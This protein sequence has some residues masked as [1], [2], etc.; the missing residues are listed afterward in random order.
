M[1]KCVPKQED[2]TSIPPEV[3]HAPMKKAI[4]KKRKVGKKI[5]EF[6]PAELLDAAI[7]QS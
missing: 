6:K 2:E 3:N 1:V 5:R 7:E 4:H